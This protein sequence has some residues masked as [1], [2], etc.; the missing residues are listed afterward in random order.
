[1]AK[2]T[3][4]QLQVFVMTVE[5][6]RISLAA[7]YCFM[8]QPAASMALQHLEEALAVPLFDRVGKRLRINSNGRLLF[9]K[10]RQLLDQVSEVESLFLDAD[11]ELTGELHMGCSRTIGMYM[12][13]SYLAE[14]KQRYPGINLQV[15]MAN[16]RDLVDQLLSL[17]LDV[18]FVEGEVV[19]S[20][21]LSSQLWREDRMVVI[22]RKNH[23]LMEAEQVSY[24]DLGSYPWVSREHGSGTAS[25][26]ER[27]AQGKFTIKPEIILS[28]FEAIKSY[29]ANSDCL[30]C[31]SM[32]VIQNT[33]SHS[34]MTLSAECFEFTRPLNWVVNDQK[35]Q[36]HVFELFRENLLTT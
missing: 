1:M 26:V 10:A 28:D 2:M 27:Q 19:E 8:T 21:V 23:P 12:L 36:S 35:Y 5:H 33:A 22:A 20:S 24:E 17:S 16:T 29:V 30:S 18:A 34:V 11:G 13:P 14:F 32:S 3:L 31:V 15:S 7:E 6:E 25:W 4:K 9:P